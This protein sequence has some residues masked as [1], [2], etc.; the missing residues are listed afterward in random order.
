MNDNDRNWLTVRRGQAPLIVSLP[1]TGTQIPDAFAGDLVSPWL[2]RKDADWW[3]DKLYGFAAALD[4]TVI[5]TAISRTVIDVNRDPS[6]ASLY[7]G[8]AT[9]ELVPMTTF[10]GEPLYRDGRTK[11]SPDDMAARRTQY[12]EP[13]HAALSA[14]IAR[15]RE[16]HSNIAL[17]DC[18][19]IR[20][21]IPRLF[22]GELPHFNLGTNKGVSC[23]PAYS[24]A[25]AAICAETNFSFV[26][27]GRFT[28]GWITRRYGD[29]AGGVHAI[30]MEHACRGYMVDPPG[31]VSPDNWP[32]PY[33]ALYALPMSMA[34]QEILEACLKLASSSNGRQQ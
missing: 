33:D 24:D 9:T 21:V 17:Y 10:D 19:S 2:A 13:Y 27:N 11:L 12:F 26:A 8:Q 34:L 4:A 7:P 18:H 30:Q 29:P 15:L 32:S 14:E 1:H 22:D 23:D 5:H 3:I 31:P 16:I 6:G 20:S 28:G 25:I